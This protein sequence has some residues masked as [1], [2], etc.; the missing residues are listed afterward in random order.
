M[1]PE[2][3][4]YC[5][6]H[7]DDFTCCGPKRNLDW[8]EDKLASFYELSRGGRLGPGADDLNEATVLNRVVRWTPQGLEYEADPRQGEKLLEELGLDE[9]T[10]HSSTPYNTRI[11]RS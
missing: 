8:F 4:L 6:V 7:G 1:H 9:G 3:R 2:K 5:S 11:Q 10:N